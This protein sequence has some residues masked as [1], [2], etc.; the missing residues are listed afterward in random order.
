MVEANE[1]AFEVVFAGLLD[2]RALDP[3]VFERQA[4]ALDEIGDVVAERRGVLDDVFFGLFERHE[5]AALAAGRAVNEELEAKSVLPHPGPPHTSVG[6][7]SGSPP[8]VISSKP[9]IP[10]ATFASDVDVRG[11]G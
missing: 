6:R 9:S 5:D 1:E 11:F 8:P 10:V 4:L 7:P 2:L 3:D